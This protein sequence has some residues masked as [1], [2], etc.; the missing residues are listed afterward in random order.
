MLSNE[1]ASVTK[2]QNDKHRKMLETLM[3]LPDNKECADCLSKGPRWASVNLGIFVC[4]QCSGIHRSLGVHISK[5]RSVTLDTWLPEQVAF[6]Q[7]MGNVKA[8]QRWEAD[9]PPNFKRPSEN[10]RSGLET[11]IRAKYEARRWVQKSNRSPQREERRSSREERWSLREGVSRRAATEDDRDRK[12]EN[13]R[14]GNPGKES[15]ERYDGHRERD[16]DHRSDGSDHREL[17]RVIQASMQYAGTS[18][19][20]RT[21][22]NGVKSGSRVISA[23]ASAS[24]RTS[25]TESNISV[26]AIQSPP[27]PAATPVVA[28]PSAPPKIDTGTDLFDLLNINYEM[29]GVAV[30]TSSPGDDDFWA[31]FQSAK[32]TPSTPD[33]KSILRILEPSLAVS[34]QRAEPT[35]GTPVRNSGIV[36]LEDL[37]KGSLEA[38]SKPESLPSKDVRQSI[39]SLFETAHISS[40]YNI[41]QRQMVALAQQQSMFLSTTTAARLHGSCY[42]G[43]HAPKDEN[44]GSVI[45]N[46]AAFG[47]VWPKGASVTGGIVSNPVGF[48]N[49]CLNFPQGGPFLQPS[50]RVS[51]RADIGSLNNAPAAT[52]SLSHDAEG[53]S[54][55]AECTWRRIIVR[56][57]R[58]IH[59]HR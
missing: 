27:H 28:S 4:I 34:G 51:V 21:P 15:V 22:P 52:L 19:H 11:F 32:S 41:Q 38:G 17:P 43:H 5:V 36:G 50:D 48:P 31:T 44:E 53:H 49:G 37:F 23:A 16:T 2:E 39:L 56:T 57:H 3:K 6:M 14:H 54:V 20:S 42:Q 8:N 55:P 47:Q 12:A 30:A 26:P 59:N 7:S 1:K 9:L 33:E 24:R 45:S 18:S 46:G 40:P 35:I 29:P 10:D 58:S 25:N 13:E